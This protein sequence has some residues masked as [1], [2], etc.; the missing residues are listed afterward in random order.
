MQ[1]DPAGLQ[2]DI[3]HLMTVTQYLFNLLLLN[4]VSDPIIYSARLKEV[5]RK[6]LRIITL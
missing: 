2:E 6:L 3:P 4:T 1:L 5:H